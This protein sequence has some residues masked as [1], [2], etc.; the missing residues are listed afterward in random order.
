[1]THSPM[2]ATRAGVLV[3]L[4]LLAGAGRGARL[5]VVARKGQSTSHL[6]KFRM[7]KPRSSYCAKYRGQPYYS[8]V[9]LGPGDSVAL[10]CQYCGMYAVREKLWFRA[11]FVWRRPWDLQE[12]LRQLGMEREVL[13]FTSPLD[14]LGRLKKRNKKFLMSKE[15]EKREARRLR[16]LKAAAPWPTSRGFRRKYG[17]HGP[18]DIGTERLKQRR[19]LELVWR[20]RLYHGVVS[21]GEEGKFLAKFRYKERMGHASFTKE[22]REYVQNLKMF[23]WLYMRRDSARE[24]L[25]GEMD[26]LWHVWLYT[27]H[28]LYPKRKQMTW[29][30]N[31]KLV[32]D[33]IRK[34][35]KQTASAALTKAMG[36]ITQ[37][38]Y[39][40]TLF[41]AYDAA[42][43]NVDGARLADDAQDAE[44]GER[45][46]M[47][48][49]DKHKVKALLQQRI[50]H[51]NFHRVVN[52]TQTTL[53][54]KFF[55][56]TKNWKS[57]KQPQYPHGILQQSLHFPWD[58]D[59]NKKMAHKI[60]LELLLS[61]VSAGDMVKAREVADSIAS[62]SQLRRMARQLRVYGL[63]R[64]IAGRTLDTE[65]VQQTAAQLYNGT[66]MVGLVADTLNYEMVTQHL[67][68]VFDVPVREYTV[69]SR[70]SHLKP[71]DRH[72][73]LSDESLVLYRAVAEDT[74]LYTCTS[75]FLED[76]TPSCFT[77]YLEVL[78]E[79]GHFSQ[80]E[81]NQ[82]DY[83]TYKKRVELEFNRVLKSY[84]KHDDGFLK[85][86]V[87]HILEGSETEC[88]ACSGKTGIKK[89][90]IELRIVN[91][92]MKMKFSVIQKVRD[93]VSFSRIMRT[94][95]YRRTHAQEQRV[96]IHVRSSDIRRLAPSFHTFARDKIAE[97]M[98]VTPCL[99]MRVCKEDMEN[100]T[101]EDFFKRQS[102][103]YVHEAKAGHPVKMTCPTRHPARV[104]WYFNGQPL[105]PTRQV[106]INK[107][108]V[109]IAKVTANHTGNY[110]CVIA[111][112]EG[113]QTTFQPQGFVYLKMNTK[114]IEIQL[115]TVLYDLGVLFLLLLL[116]QV[117]LACITPLHKWYQVEAR[118]YTFMMSTLYRLKMAIDAM[119][120]TEDFEETRKL[121]RLRLIQ[122]AIESRK[123]CNMVRLQEQLA[124]LTEV[125]RDIEEWLAL[126]SSEIWKLQNT[127]HSQADL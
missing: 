101:P 70:L 80:E 103:A 108:W 33:A 21:S 74:G 91:T 37:H 53:L 22:L 87:F 106:F 51:R 117:P 40:S 83:E 62:S 34:Y 61:S 46:Q 20:Y 23:P 89:R 69:M 97:F 81:G 48:P 45:G 12:R 68:G 54:S 60:S 126:L 57:G 29:E 36:Q 7:E 85:D 9:T 3:L 52:T 39:R 116:V 42:A 56:E 107:A 16:R 10:P 11:G 104:V 124:Q 92:R 90:D 30:Q 25:R 8:T 111:I 99:G 98:L 50:L 43:M 121:R 47:Q 72:L 96:G 79:R 118:R 58:K 15:E 67:L 82:E 13:V 93:R 35:G 44:K 65:E 26:K 127:N 2:S 77:Y 66:K 6:L 88:S 78:E 17:K 4:S 73:Q 120:W 64:A 94:A 112:T 76:F 113:G 1:M 114:T 14:L 122:K 105:F 63:V 71:R 41:K 123:V 24:Q 28:Q 5:P 110:S 86:T 27:S 115:Y 38:Y 125:D 49:L 18:S 100:L 84:W 102:L 59:E 31:V 95:A 32:R 19:L 75:G 109:G 119:G 55:E